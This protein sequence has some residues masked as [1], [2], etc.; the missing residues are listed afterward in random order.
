MARNYWFV[1]ICGEA[2]EEGA[3]DGP[4]EVGGLRSGIL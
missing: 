1:K 2:H 4:R 3:V